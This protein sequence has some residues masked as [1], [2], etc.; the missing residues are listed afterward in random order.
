MLESRGVSKS[1]RVL[2]RRT[3]MG[4]MLQDLLHPRR[5]TRVALRD[6]SRT[7]EKGRRV[8]LA[9]KNGSGKSTLL[10]ILAG[11]MTPTTGEILYDGTP[12]RRLKNRYKSDIGVVFGH[13]G[14]LIWE[15]ALS[16]SLQF[17]KYVYRLDTPKFRRR[18][19]FLAERLR[20]NELLNVPI[21]EMSLGQRMRSEI[22]G[23]LIHSPSTLILD[24]ATIGLDVSVKDEIYSLIR[25]ET[26]NR[27]TTII[28]STHDVHNI[29][30]MANDLIVIEN[31]RI[32]YD[33]SPQS[34]IDA[35]VLFQKITLR[36][37]A[38]RDDVLPLLPTNIEILEDAIDDASKIVMRVR[39]SAEAADILKNQTLMSYV[40]GLIIEEETLHD[41][42]SRFYHGE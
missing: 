8:C 13:R 34:F 32:V 3:G 17:L 23:A 11:A 26:Q 25:H 21:R 4:G 6:V 14:Q 5:V 37:S 18:L 2:D 10:K 42:L 41:I 24:E 33:G 36:I 7:F 20:L 38:P 12:I 31:G 40:D 19:D 15:L 22:A 27:N 9:G 1:F 16:E 35:H 39:S 28:F 29:L 30:A